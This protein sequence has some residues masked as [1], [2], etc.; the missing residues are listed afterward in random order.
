MARIPLTQG[1]F[2]LVDDDVYEA[3]SQHRWMFGGSGYAMRSSKS[4]GIYLHREILRPTKGYEVDHIN[5]DKLD[6]RSS[7]LRVCEK[8]GN[9]RNKGIQSNN[10]SGFK[11]VS[12]CGNRWRAQISRK[13]KILHIGLFRTKEEAASAYDST[14]VKLHG[15]F[16]KTN[17]MI[18]SYV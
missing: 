17:K 16:A 1:K 8:S 2:A 10:T 3:L 11:G 15:P 5:G 12:A 14:A 13:K 4:K 9:Q 6:N 18:N 7:N